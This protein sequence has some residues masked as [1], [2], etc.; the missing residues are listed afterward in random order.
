VARALG[1]RALRDLET[2]EKYLGAAEEMRKRL[3]VSEGRGDL[4]PKKR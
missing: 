3:L 1:N 4:K 2:P